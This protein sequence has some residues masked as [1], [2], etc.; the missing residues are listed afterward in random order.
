M[1]ISFSVNVPF[2]HHL[3]I[4]LK[5]FGGGLYLAERRGDGVV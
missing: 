2:I 1:S 5:K 3:G 4:T